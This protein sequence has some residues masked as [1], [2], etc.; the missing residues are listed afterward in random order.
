M[1]SPII[2][3]WPEADT[4]Y[5]CATQAVTSGVPLTFTKPNVVQNIFSGATTY[6][7]GMPPQNIREVSLTSSGNL[8]AVNFVISGDNG[9]GTPISVTIAGPNATTVFSGPDY[10]FG[11][12]YSITPSA[13][14]SATVS[15]GTGNLGNTS[16]IEFDKYNKS[17]TYAFTYTTGTTGVLAITP[18]YLPFFTSFVNGNIVYN[19]QDDFE[20][21]NSRG[22]N[23]EA[24]N[25]YFESIADDGTSP[26][27]TGPCS[28]QTTGII[29]GAFCTNV[30]FTS[31]AA[32]ST[33]PFVCT[34]MQQGAKF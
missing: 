17:A 18:V 34:I 7:M 33:T 8:S 29:M 24:P 15:V 28:I 16:W 10:P 2:I 11:N 5:F 13:T 31:T 25:V 23:L 30:G 1:G 21:T 20:T 9:Y 32:R 22:I 4:D 6:N 3:T 26:T 14:S 12:I 19:A 27:L